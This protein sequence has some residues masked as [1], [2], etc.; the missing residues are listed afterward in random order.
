[1]LLQI[2]KGRYFERETLT[3]CNDYYEREILRM[4]L[5][6]YRRQKKP[7]NIVLNDEH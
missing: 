5:K 2:S 1:M 3:D 4:D 7:S 6:C